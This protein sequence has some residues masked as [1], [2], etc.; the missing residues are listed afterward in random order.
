M[1]INVDETHY[2]FIINLKPELFGHVLYAVHRT[3]L[4]SRHWNYFQ[5]LVY[6]IFDLLLFSLSSSIISY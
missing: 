3:Y 5:A 2:C 6:T 4:T 1:S